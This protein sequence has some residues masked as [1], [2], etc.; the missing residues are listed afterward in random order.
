MRR[1]R[2]AL[3]VLGGLA[4]LAVLAVVLHILSGDDG[5]SLVAAADGGWVYLA[6]FLLVF[7]D[8]LFPVLPGETTLNAASTLAAQGTLRLDLVILA[9]ALG[10]IAGDSCLFWCARRSRARVEPMVAKARQHALLLTTLELLGSRPPVVLI[11]G[12]YVPGM[13]FLINVTYGLSTY[14]YRRFLLWSA[15]GGTLW[16][17]T[18]CLLAYAVGTALADFPLASVII[19]GA[20]TTL[21]VGAFIWVARR[22]RHQSP[23]VTT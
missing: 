6:V 8:A 4:L 18:T 23:K 16:S 22:Y 7:G 14:P 13:R 2:W 9:G 5:F 10:A 1:R 11:A 3:V 17:L 19:S 15:I 20:L 12:R 21:A